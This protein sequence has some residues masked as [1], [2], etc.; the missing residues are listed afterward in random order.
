[1]A[2]L[3]EH[4]KTIPYFQELEPSALARL[5]ASVFEVR[6]DRG[7]ILFSEGDPAEAMYG[8]QSGQVK[9]LKLSPDGREQVLRVMG[10]GECFNEVPVFDEGPNPA[11]AQA[12]EPAVL[13]GIRRTDMRR[14]V[15]EHPA[16]A[17]GFL[18]VFAKKLR[19]FTQKVEDLSFRSVTSRVAKLL[20]EL[21]EDDGRGNLR[22]KQQFTQQELANVVGTAREMIGRAF[23]V[24]EKEGAIKLTRHRVVIVSKTTLT[25]ML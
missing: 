23:K 10:P 18:K 3:L 17:I 7:Q 13:W 15:E 5:Q 24:L 1:M 19:F 4:L 25:R 2:M 11:N 14:L 6:L 21:A 9:I 12:L 20:L 8:V 22:L 16:V